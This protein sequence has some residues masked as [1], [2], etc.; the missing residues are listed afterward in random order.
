MGKPC[1][2]ISGLTQYP[3]GPFGLT[4]EI[5]L[6]GKLNCHTIVTGGAGPKGL[7][8]ADLKNAVAAFAKKLKPHLEHARQH[9]VTIAIENHANS[10]IFSHDSLKWLAEFT[11]QE[12]LGIAL[13][14]YHLEQEAH[15]IAR[16]IKSLGDRVKVFYAWQHGLGCSKKLPKEEELLQLPGRG[17]LDFGPIVNALVETDYRG[18]TT[19]F[20]HPVPRGIPILPT[21]KQVTAEINRAKAYLEGLAPAKK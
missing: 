3:L 18:W 10:L 20:M 15:S 1:T 7:A 14:P 9:G 11:E 12:N 13:A 19:V 2:W 6:A 4:K 21:M 5:E 17:D 16:L 8:G